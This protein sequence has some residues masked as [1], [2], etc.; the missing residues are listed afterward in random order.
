MVPVLKQCNEQRMYCVRAR[1]T[2]GAEWLVGY[3]ASPALDGRVIHFEVGHGIYARKYRLFPALRMG[4]SQQKV[5]A[6][7][8]NKCVFNYEFTRSMA[9]NYTFSWLNNYI[10]HRKYCADGF[11]LL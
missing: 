10:P 4:S 7:I 6:R 2:G 11:A 9:K 5:R 8:W 3:Y 1:H